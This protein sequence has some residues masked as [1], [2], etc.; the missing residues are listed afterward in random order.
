MKKIKLVILGFLF[1]TC[2]LVWIAVFAQAHS[3]ELVVN[4][5]DVGQG[6]AILI[7][8]PYNQQIL[9]DG[10]PN[11]RILAKLGSDMP[12][13]DRTIELIISTHPHADHLFG[14]VSVLDRYQ[15]EQILET[16]VVCDTSVCQKWQQ[17]IKEKNIPTRIAQAGQKIKL[18]QGLVINVL[19][20]FEN[21]ENQK[22]KDLNNTSIM[23][24]LI[25]G[26]NSFLFTGDA[27]KA[28]E[29]EI[30]ENNI[31]VDS[32]VLKLG[33][34][35]S[36]DATSDEFLAAASPIIA[37]ISVSKN[38]KYGHPH[39]ETLEKFKTIK[40]YRTD[41]NGDIEIRSDGKILISP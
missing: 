20:P 23:T 39:S 30:L 8:T 16:G 26:K 19:Y 15:V 37:V 38:N 12:F 28:E 29:Y 40:L 14:L 10:G 3:Q 2:L 33:H 18:G 17:T 13:W 22:I 32:D 25:Y 6:D 31:Y 36:N 27:E 35:G 21:L 1:V 5:Y 7:E 24:R 34:Q 9:I 4:F 41:I 11:D